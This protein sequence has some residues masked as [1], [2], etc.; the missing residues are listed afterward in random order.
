M[1]KISLS[2]NE[3][4]LRIR[5]RISFASWNQIHI[6]VKNWILTHPH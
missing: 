1:V 6:R 2:L 4:G 3:P 5:I